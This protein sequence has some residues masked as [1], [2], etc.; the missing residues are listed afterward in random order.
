MGH[1]NE[2]K[3]EKEKQNGFFKEI[4]IEIRDTIVFEVVWN[5][6]MLIPRMMIR[7]IKNIW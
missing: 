3:K 5:I 6:L 7:V 1:D 4:L 2:K